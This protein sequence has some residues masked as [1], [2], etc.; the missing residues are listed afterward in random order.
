[1]AT[2]QASHRALRRRS[3][4][5]RR[6]VV[7]AA[8]LTALV[9]LGQVA[10]GYF[11]GTGSSTGSVTTGTL[12]APTGV[13]GAQT[14]GTGTVTV[15]WT[16]SSGTPAPD[17]YYVRRLPSSG[18]AVAACGTSAASLTTATSCS[19]TGVPLGSHTYEV[20]A[21]FRSWTA[22]SAPSA[23]VTV[24]QASQTITFTSSPVS[25]TYGGSYTVTAT[26]GGS[27]NPVTFGS[28]TPGVCSVSGSAV[29]FLH[30]GT[31]T[32]NADQAGSTYYSAA[33]QNQ[34][35]F[36]VAKAAQTIS[37]TSTAPSAA[38]VGGAGY[39]PA[40]TGGAS[41]NPVTFTIDASTGGVCSLSG[42]VVTYQHAGTCTVNANQAGTA[43]Y[44]AASQVQ[45][46]YTVGPGAQAITFTSTAPGNAKV[47]G[48][49]YTVTATGGASGNA[50]TFSSGS[51]SVCT[52]SG[53]TVTF[54]GAGTC[55]VNANQAGNADY[56]A[57][58]QV[59]QSFGV[60]KQD[61][62]ITFTST[63][64][65]SATVGGTYAATATA[66]S[67]LTVTF[68]TDTASVCTVTSAGAVSFV[69]AGTCHVNANQAGNGT[70]NAAPQVQQSFTVAGGTFAITGRTSGSPQNTT[71]VSGTGTVG[72]NVSVYICNG[73]RASCGS[74]S[75]FLVSNSNFTNP[76]T[77]T[78]GAGGT[79][80][81]TFTKLLNGAGT[82]TTQAFQT[83]PSATSNV[84]VFSVS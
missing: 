52:V 18:P 39:T 74:G 69:A 56:L 71:I 30:A 26:G 54:V 33:P 40:A 67:G 24:A 29:S 37:F 72:A 6:L 32:I 83:S 64:P 38:V 68:S 53:S 22:T 21:V 82:F 73:N 46:S 31:C 66:S 51:P 77:T 78:V 48:S 20:V 45:Q 42:G 10:Y 23:T 28:A 76:Q 59:Q 57:A 5:P 17:G 60:T 35:T 34:Q 16:A 62:T 81:V 41:G 14:S 50:V 61:Q 79:W 11:S 58:A 19:D 65:G 15:S 3:P 8:T 2:Y 84:V 1:M 12:A 43:D 63:A 4:H 9:A 36:T 44:L 55:V 25:P 27:G 13:T 47:G 80:S 75:A 49:T 70:Y 7:V